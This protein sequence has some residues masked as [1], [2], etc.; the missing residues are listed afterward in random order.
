[1]RKYGLLA[2]AGVLCALA[3]AILA[4]CGDEYETDYNT[5][6]TDQEGWHPTYIPL[7]DGS[8]LTCIVNDFKEGVWCK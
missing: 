8:T 7:R 3:F 5:N 1:M 6:T 2:E 4:G